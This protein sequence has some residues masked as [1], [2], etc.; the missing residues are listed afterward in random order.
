MNNRDINVALATLNE[1]M[2]L[3]EEE[4]MENGGEVTELHKMLGIAVGHNGLIIHGQKEAHVHE[5][6][7]DI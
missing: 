4:Y 6:R 5:S 2:Y 3:L 1:S 7:C